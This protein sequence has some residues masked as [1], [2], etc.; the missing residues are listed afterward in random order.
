MLCCVADGMEHKYLPGD[1]KGSIERERQR[2]QFAAEDLM[3]DD[4][5]YSAC[6][7]CG[8]VV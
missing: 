8:D 1:E 2:R 6:S 4:K 7:M 3:G 5:K